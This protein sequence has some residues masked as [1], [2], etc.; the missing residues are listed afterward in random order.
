M[1]IKKIILDVLSKDSLTYKKPDN[2]F[3]FIASTYNLDANS[4]KAEFKKLEK[5]GDIFEEEGRFV[6]FREV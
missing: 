2:L 6:L 1:Q 5:S 4:V 3:Y